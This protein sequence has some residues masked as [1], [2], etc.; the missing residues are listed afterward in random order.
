MPHDIVTI[1]MLFGVGLVAGTINVI[2][3]G[4]SM[5]TLPVL[6]LLGLPPNVANGTNRVAI[7]V[8]NKGA[9]WSFRRLGLIS[10]HWI[11]LAVPPALVGVVFGTWAA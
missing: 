1:V 4:G 3:G 2:A 5:I 10:G 8:Q 11:R 6:I 7:L 9:T